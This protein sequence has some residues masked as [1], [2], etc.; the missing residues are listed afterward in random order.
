MGTSPLIQVDELR[1]LLAGPEAGRPVVLD[2][3]YR[4]GSSTGFQ[5]FEEGHVPERHTSAWTPS[6][7]PSVPT[8]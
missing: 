8:E 6:W 7:R 1:R 5:V 3:R 2:V 4:M